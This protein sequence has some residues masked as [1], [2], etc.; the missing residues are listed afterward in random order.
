MALFAETGSA[1]SK[2]QPGGAEVTKLS[3][4]QYFKLCSLRGKKTI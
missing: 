3:E 2:A 4:D 1:V